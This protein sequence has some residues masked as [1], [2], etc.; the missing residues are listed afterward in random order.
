MRL[1]T[2]RRSSWG[3]TVSRH[4]RRC[5]LAQHPAVLPAEVAAEAAMA[6]CHAFKFMKR[7]KQLPRKPMSQEVM[8]KICG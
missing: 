6:R 3:A 2:R 1:K 4:P 8:S 7:L 5:S